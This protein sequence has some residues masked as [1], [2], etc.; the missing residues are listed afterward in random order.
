MTNTNKK[1]VEKMDR[2]VVEMNIQRVIYTEKCSICSKEIKGTSESQV[3]SNLKIHI[4]TQHPE[5]S[6]IKDDTKV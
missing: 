2:K 1:E 6:I 5:S 4:L 3:I